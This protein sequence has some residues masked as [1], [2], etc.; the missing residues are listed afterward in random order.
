MEG[1]SWEEAEEYNKKYQEV[2]DILSIKYP[3]ASMDIYSKHFFSVVGPL[4]LNPTFNE[5][6]N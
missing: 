2:M 1:L 4:P 5:T 3:L 6:K